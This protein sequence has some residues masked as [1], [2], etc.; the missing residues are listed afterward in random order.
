MEKCFYFVVNKRLI[1]IFTFCNRN[2]NCPYL[3]VTWVEYFILVEGPSVKLSVSLSK[4]RVKKIK[5]WYG[6]DYFWRWYFIYD[7]VSI[8]WWSFSVLIKSKQRRMINSQL[9]APPLIGRAKRIIAALMRNMCRVSRAECE[10][11]ALLHML[12]ATFY[13]CFPRS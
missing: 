3:F 13:E 4:S 6:L 7:R 1:K 9:L 10:I 5:N 2:Q 12:S 8:C 11:S